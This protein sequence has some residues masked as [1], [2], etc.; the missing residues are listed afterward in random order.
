MHPDEL[1]TLPPVKPS[2]GDGVH[3][4]ATLSGNSVTA[5]YGLGQQ[6]PP[7]AAQQSGT[8][9]QVE[10]FLL[11]S[12]LGRGG[13]G[14]V[15]LARQLK[16]NRLVALKMILNADHS[17]AATKQRFLAEAEAIAQL[18]HPGI[19]QVYEFGTHEGNPYFALEYIS[20]GSLEKKLA[21][22]PQPPRESAELVEKLAHA[23][24]SAHER[25]II[26]RDLKPANILLSPESTVLSSESKLA[27]F[28]PQDTALKTL[29]P[30]I[31]DFGLVKKEGSDMTATGVIL[32]T[33][34]Y[35]APEQ[36]D[37]KKMIG[38][39][40]DVYAL[41]AILYECLTG[42]P[43]FKASTPLD[44]VLQVVN[45]EPVSVR[46]S[47]PKTPRDLET[48]C[49][50]CLQKEP[51]KRYGSA[52]ALGDDLRRFLNHEP[53][54]AHPVG[55]VEKM[56]RWCRRHPA[57]A[58]MAAGIVVL[59]LIGVVVA[60]SVAQWVAN[61]SIQNVA[62]AK[63]VEE[64]K[65]RADEQTE[66]VQTE[67][68]TTRRMLTA[69]LDMVKSKDDATSNAA[70]N[71]IV[72]LGFATTGAVDELI[73]LMD[74]SGEVVTPADE[75]RVEKYAQLLAKFGPTVIPTLRKG[76]SNPNITRW[77]CVKALG[78]LGPPA[79]EAV[80]DLEALLK[81]E[82]NELIQRDIRESIRKIE[83]Q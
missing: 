23:V 73:K 27:S 52:A 24:G 9:P 15:Y 14:I 4:V 44:T 76:L 49:L 72:Q 82:Q 32:G 17:D 65:K 18:Q 19:V 12:E 46:K 43:P 48:I 77:G 64:E 51:G 45:T 71:T 22:V 67:K 38:P 7:L 39:S 54:L 30:K 28:K 42:R 47:Q 21:G 31:T 58:G 75:A 40:A 33:P 34:S 50:K 83:K 74:V 80:P 79:Y 60:N 20:G 59:I 8:L 10:G 5:Q 11:E 68:N 16:L 13:M 41:G 81:Q 56:W 2:S 35:M 53:I 63:Q 70:I 62:R 57:V 29:S 3:D 78:I 69:L 55:R 1:P 61:E 25:G 26:H 66:L 6:P 36:A 37:S